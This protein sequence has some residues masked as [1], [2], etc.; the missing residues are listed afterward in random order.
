MVERTIYNDEQK[1]FAQSVR[2]FIAKEITP[3]NAQWEKDHMVSRE[4]WLK[5]GEAGLLCMQ[6]SEEYGGLGITDFRY[7]A[8]ITEE[9]GRSGC[10][11][12]AVG[13]PL[14]SDIVSP[15]I[16]HYGNE[17]T[18]KKYLPKMVTGEWIAAIAMTEPGA[19]SDLQN[20]RTTAVD[21]GDHYLV[22]GSKT[23]ITNGYL[24]DLV[25]VAV[26]TDPSK[27]AKGTSLLVI[28]N[29]MKGYTKGKPFEKVGLHAQDTC[30][31]FFENVEVPK[32]NL[33][34]N[35]G[36]GFKYMMTELSQERL[37]VA[38][39]A[40]GAAEGTVE[41]TVQYTKERMAFG[42]PI[43]ELQNTRFKLAEQ[44]T[45]VQ[46]GRI[47]ADQCITLHCDKKLDQ[48]TASMAKY[49]L[50]DLQSKVADECLQLHGGYG[51]MWEYQVARAWADARVQ[52]I[53]AGT[54][55]IMKELIARHILK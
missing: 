35:E 30:E 50:T 23:F 46:V 51:Y 13:Y 34:S 15:Y 8:I 41:K 54:N 36:E 19:G 40:I 6:V 48:A 4:S 33:L 53:Y 25:V 12:P 27:G 9:L 55:E 32:E 52:R 29:S 42:K 44:A 14:H 10:A 3:N 7:N 1:M 18:K 22:N 2:D 20:I 39:S 47:F 5:F 31:L 37:V 28:D 11:G 45:E 17:A 24:S 43:A 26:K 38:L 16:E 49:W 21:K